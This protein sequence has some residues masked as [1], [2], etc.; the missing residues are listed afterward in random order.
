MKT[1][2]ITF[3]L[4]MIFASCEKENE[5]ND[6]CPVISEKLIASAV[7][8]AFKEKYSTAVVDKW[9]NKD[10]T[11][12]CALFIIDGRKMLSQFSNDGT[13]VHEEA[14]VEQ[15]G[16]H[17]NNDDKDSGCECESDDED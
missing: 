5:H 8:Q 6:D 13:F 17:E 7:S 10:N 12:Y 16:E 11:G 2:L 3:A 1:L 9:F 4:A 14:D 15:E